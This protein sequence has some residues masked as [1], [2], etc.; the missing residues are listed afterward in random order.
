MKLMCVKFFIFIS[1]WLTIASNACADQRI[2]N[3]LDEYI[4]TKLG[5]PVFYTFPE[6]S[7]ASLSNIKPVEATL[8]N[9]KHPES[10][11]AATSLGLRIYSHKP[12][13]KLASSLAASRFIQTGD[14]LLS[15]RPEWGGAGPYTNIQMGISHAGVAYIKNGVVKNIDMPLTPEYLGEL[16][17]EHYR[18]TKAIHVIRPRGLTN[19]QKENIA[20]WASKLE[21][22]APKIYPNK[23]SFN[24]DYTSPNFKP[25]KPLTFVKQLGQ[26]ALGI[27]NNISL[28]MYCSEF[29]WSLLSLRDCDPNN[30]QA[31]KEEGV[32]RCINPIFVPLHM[33]GDFVGTNKQEKSSV[34][35]SDG[36]LLTINSMGLSN[37]DRDRLLTSVF[38]TD[39]KNN[40]KLSPGHK[41]ISDLMS[42]VFD[43][44]R[45]V[46]FGAYYNIQQ[47]NDLREQ[48][49]SQMKD[50]Y[51]PPSFVI[52]TLPAKENPLRVM[53]Y[54]G[55]VTYIEQ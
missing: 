8:I 28:K 1:I 51:S 45:G 12:D 37:T 19:T 20:R 39:R 52:L 30:A 31:F 22:E 50:N 54:V 21:S 47:A 33:S 11:S 26:L 23:I 42:P 10:K 32:P 14:I 40:A 7:Y 44:L 6:S 46:Y 41:S 36:P 3:N 13:T 55:T 4:S 35:L 25:G 15:F 5:I 48:F 38:T 43:K 29:A 9:F 16:N 18:E 53:D 49:N 27:P 2:K 34:G 24:Q 17:S